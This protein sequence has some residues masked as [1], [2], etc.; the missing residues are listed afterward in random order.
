MCKVCGLGY[1][2]CIWNHTVPHIPH[3]H[4][5]LVMYIISLVVKLEVP[6]TLGGRMAMGNGS[7]IEGIYLYITNGGGIV[8]RN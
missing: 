6:I 8:I 2:N 1:H 7:Q 5:T 3:F 4:H